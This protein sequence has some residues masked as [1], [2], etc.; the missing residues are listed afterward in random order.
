MRV[1]VAIPLLNEE[2]VLPELLRRVVTVLDSLQGGPHE[3]V[4]V[5]DGSTDAT[6]AILADAVA[7]DAR[8]RVVR[9]SRNFG[10]Q[11]AIT[12][13]LDHVRGDVVVVMDGDLQDQ[14][15]EIP[16]FLNVQAAG[17]DV[18]YAQR[19]T[20]PESL[21]LRAAY[22]LFYRAFARLSRVSVP[23][24]AGDF[25]LITRR[26]VM[27]MRAAPE[28]NR[29][30]R[31]LRAWVGFRQIGIPVDRA[32]RQGGTSKYSFVALCRLALD[33]VFAFSTLPIRAAMAAGTIAIG[34]AVLFAV[35][36]VYARVVLG[37]SPAG[38]TSIILVVTF[39]AGVNLFF[40]GVVGEYVGRVY[41]ETKQRP[42]YVVDH[43][44]EREG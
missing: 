23:L 8:I 1:S 33:G 15:E 19:A 11:S 29:Y 28:R 44:I 31:G 35:Y 9:L 10:H 42:L 13:A 26:V 14:P 5:D 27:A 3:L 40:L 24:D 16:R 20:R 41:E 17:Y 7:G 30:L 43:V 12:A 4:V 32:L 37:R 38:F 21:P 34:I 6:P 2:A 36:A 22:Y 25:A 18:V 39:L